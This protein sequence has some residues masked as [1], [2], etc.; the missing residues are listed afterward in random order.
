LQN[1]TDLVPV[2]SLKP[3]QHTHI[4]PYFPKETQTQDV[5]IDEDW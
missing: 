3:P 4:V 1:T 2:T 5:L